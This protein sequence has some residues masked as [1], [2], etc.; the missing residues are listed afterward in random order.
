[1]QNVTTLP[2][3]YHKPV[4]FKFKHCS[5]FRV[6]KIV[7]QSSLNLGFGPKELYQFSFIPM[8][9]IWQIHTF[10]SHWDYL[11]VFIKL[12]L[13]PGVLHE[14]L[15]PPFVKYTKQVVIFWGLGFPFHDDN[16][17]IGTHKL[18]LCWLNLF[19]KQQTKYSNTCVLWICP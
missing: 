1:M 18:F 7:S 9:I 12:C 15:F 5:S 14:T 19:W 13:C 4:L 8:I 3:F 17:C 10:K 16:A 11:N 6:I 2:H